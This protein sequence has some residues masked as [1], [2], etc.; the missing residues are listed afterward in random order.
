[1]SAQQLEL[2]PSAPA[3]VETS[4]PGAPL[5]LITGLPGDGKTLYALATFAVGKVGVKT[6]GVPGC[7]LPSFDPHKW[8][9]EL[10]TGETGI[11]DEAQEVF[12]P[13]N[14][15][16]DPPQHYVLNKIR[17]GGRALVLLTQHPNMIDSRVRR[18]CGRHI[19]IKRIFGLE[20]AVAHEWHGRIGDV[21]TCADSQQTLFVFP[22]AV[23]KL[24]KSADLH[25]KRA[26]VPLKVKLIPVWIALAAALM[27]GGGWY[28]Y[29]SMSNLGGKVA[30]SRQVDLVKPGASTSSSS[31]MSPARPGQDRA[32]PRT[33]QEYT[34]SYI[35]RIEGLP[36]TAPVYDE[37]TRPVRAPFPAACIA[38]TSRCNCFTQ[39]GTKLDTPEG[40][41]RSIVA[42]GVFQ[43]FED[44]DAAMAW[45]RSQAATALADRSAAHG[46]QFVQLTPVTPTA[47]RPSSLGAGVRA[48]Q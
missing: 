17:H 13:R 22:K 37:V 46:S 11:V 21:E 41:C 27:I 8:L 7:V 34:A 40:L 4:D 29:H 15:N 47:A 32:Q 2:V 3:G 35:P 31:S 39:Q 25:R 33:P 16:T 18:L 5:V 12:P 14:V 26:P 42:G 36:H 45:Q 9:D 43:E 6:A 20:R 38:S 1:V 23:Y 30:P 19:H 44:R 48:P 10:Q 24:Y 28:V